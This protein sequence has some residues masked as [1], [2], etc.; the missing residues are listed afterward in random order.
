MLIPRM[1]EGA[2][3]EILQSSKKI[4]NKETVWIQLC[5][6]IQVRWNGQVH[7]KT[8]Y[9]NADLNTNLNSSLTYCRNWQLNKSFTQRVFW[10]P[11]ISWLV[12]YIMHSRKNTNTI[13]IQIPY[14]SFSKIEKEIFSIPIAQPESLKW[15]KNVTGKLKCS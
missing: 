15:N 11:Q 4:D 8:K 9:N 13:S 1:N 6:Y 2:L 5:Q 14:T 10:A 7:W 12:T 3:L